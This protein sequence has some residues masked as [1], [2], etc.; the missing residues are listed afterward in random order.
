MLAR[1]G[2]L[3]GVPIIGVWSREGPKPT[4][5]SVLRVP[6]LHGDVRRVHGDLS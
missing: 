3:P 2:P 1:S 5:E 4:S 6:N